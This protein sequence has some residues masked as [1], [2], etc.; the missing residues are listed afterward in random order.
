M[1][2]AFGFIVGFACAFASFL[3]PALVVFGFDAAAIAALGSN[4]DT[5]TPERDETFVC[6]GS[7][8]SAFAA[9]PPGARAVSA[10]CRL[11]ATN[12]AMRGAEALRDYF[13]LAAALR[14]APPWHPE[15]TNE[16]PEAA[17]YLRNRTSAERVFQ[18]YS[19]AMMSDEFRSLVSEFYEKHPNA[20]EETP[21]GEAL[22]NE[23]SAKQDAL[24]K[25]LMAERLDALRADPAHDPEAIDAAVS[26]VFDRA[27][28]GE[29]TPSRFAM[30]GPPHGHG[31]REPDDALAPESHA[32]GLVIVAKDELNI[33]TAFF[34]D[35]RKEA[36][37]L[38]EH[39]CTLG[40]ETIEYGY[41]GEDL[42]AD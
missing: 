35:L 5:Y 30:F 1:R 8:M 26:A 24:A 14:L 33:L 3:V 7:E 17:R 31:L 42:Y 18:L 32:T 34:P 9:P 12:E 16:S 4:E 36:W 25:D 39:V 11:P 22:W 6:G 15:L 29:T 20:G 27:H 28:P 23:L 37:N 2:V 10:G 38:L 13:R 21:E 19:D 40:C 41:F